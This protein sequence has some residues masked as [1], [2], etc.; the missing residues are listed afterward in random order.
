MILTQSYNFFSILKQIYIGIHQIKNKLL[1][2]NI[3]FRKIKKE[4]FGFI[5]TKYFIN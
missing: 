4:W 5:T 2:A 3:I 1:I